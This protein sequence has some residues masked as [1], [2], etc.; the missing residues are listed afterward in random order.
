MTDDNQ[1]VFATEAQQAIFEFTILL[2]QRYVSST[3][4]FPEAMEKACSWIESL[5][6]DLRSKMKDFAEQR[7]VEEN[8][9]S[10]QH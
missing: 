10:T 5:A 8:K 7:T 4:A 1:Q 3:V 2:A 9:L 6:I